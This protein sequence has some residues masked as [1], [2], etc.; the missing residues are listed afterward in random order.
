MLNGLNVYGEA[1]KENDLSFTANLQTK[2]FKNILKTGFD[3]KINQ[4]PLFD[5]TPD[6]MGLAPV[7]TVQAHILCG[8]EGSLGFYGYHPYEIAV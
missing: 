7:K 1:V 3:L 5:T 8:S 2:S 6:A 4:N